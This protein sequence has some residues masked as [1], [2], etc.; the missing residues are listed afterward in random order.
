MSV[1]IVLRITHRFTQLQ[2]APRVVD[3]VFERQSLAYFQFRST[4][5]QSAYIHIF[6]NFDN[7]CKKV[8]FLSFGGIT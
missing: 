2:W 1:R 4:Q 6:L 3:L 7:Y 5:F 8:I